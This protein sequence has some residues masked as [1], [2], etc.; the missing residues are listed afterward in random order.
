MVGN[1]DRDCIQE[2]YLTITSFAC[3]TLGEMDFRFFSCECDV[4][5]L[6]FFI[7]PYWPSRLSDHSRYILLEEDRKS[8]SRTVCSCPSLFPAASTAPRVRMYR[9]Q[10]S[11]I[12]TRGAVEVAGRVET[13]L[14][15]NTTWSFFSPA[16]IVCKWRYLDWK[17]FFTQRSSFL[18]LSIW[19]GQKFQCSVA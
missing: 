2:F 17:I 9:G 18:F 5:V 15:K 14:K 3:S 4:I 1:A 19:V 13:E 12:P 10:F 7:E 8:V 11:S 6:T 16:L